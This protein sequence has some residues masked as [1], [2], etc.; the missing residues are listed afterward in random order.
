[1]AQCRAFML[2]MLVLY[3]QAQ[4]QVS[5][6][7]Y[8]PDPALDT[9]EQEAVYSVLEAAN[10]EVDWR[11]AY[12]SDLCSAG[13]HG[14]ACDPDS[15]NSSL[16]H[17][18]KLSLGW[19]S[20]YSNN[21]PCSATNASFSPS[22]LN[23]PFLNSLFFY[24]CFVAESRNGT[25]T[26]PPYLGSLGPQL[27]E[28]VLHENTA[29]S[30]AV[31]QELGALVGLRRLV[32]SGS[33]L[34]GPVPF[35]LGNLARIEKI[36][37][38]NNEL[39]GCVPDSIGGLGALVVLDLSRNNLSCTI[40]SSLGNLSKLSKLDL[41]ENVFSGE[42]PAAFARL[43]ILE[44]LD[45]SR[46]NLSG[47]FP[48]II[49]K[50]RHLR[51]LQLSENPLGGSLPDEIWRHLVGLVSL[52]ASRTDLVGEIPSSMGEL[53]GLAHLALDHNALTGSIPFELSRLESI[54]HMDLS[55]N[56]LTGVVPFSADFVGRLGPKLRLEG[57]AGLC[58]GSEMTPSFAMRLDFGGC[59]AA[60]MGQSLIDRGSIHGSHGS[61]PLVKSSLL[62]FGALLFV[63]V[64]CLN[65]F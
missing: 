2:L 49:S 19:V 63:L 1:M 10:P 48:S 20:D 24:R 25:F 62:L 5:D 23:L 14:V 61:R 31:P 12:P 46:N 43:I 57:N 54:Q 34:A 33:L 4:A 6:D 59:S 40:P 60:S 3:A 45:L 18:T 65:W 35:E 41:S 53:H 8:Y 58:C 42:I 22:I 39:S 38:S 11:S 32:I 52:G 64:W 47:G 36:D 37:L 26:L 9:K 27:E 44:M 13:P 50:M 29:I 7:Y 28:L 17:V 56:R 15:A 16:A 51:D 21:P 30:G 55:S